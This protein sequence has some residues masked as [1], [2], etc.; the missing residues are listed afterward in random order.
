MIVILTGLASSG[1]LG[2]GIIL[3]PIMLIFFR[4]T[5]NK[6]IM[7]VYAM[8]FG[9][10]IG[11]FLNAGLKRHPK[12]RKPFLNY[13]LSLICMPPM[14]MGTAFGV[15]INRM[16]ASAFI[17]V[18][19]VTLITYSFTKIYGRARTEYK[20][21]TEARKDLAKTTAAE[22][23]IGPVNNESEEWM[24]FDELKGILKEENQLVP[25]KKLLKTLGLIVFMIIMALLRGT[26]NFSSLAGVEYC[27]EEYWLLF[28]LAP[29][30]CLV[31][32]A[33]N[34]RTLKKTLRVKNEAGYIP[35][36]GEFELN[37]KHV[38]KLSI[39]SAFAGVLAG[40][41]GIG[42]G[43]IMGPTLLSI[44]V[45]PQSLGATAGFFIIQTSFMSFFS[46]L[47]YGEI[48]LVE[49]GF[50]LGITFIGSYVVSYILS[51]LVRKYNRPSLILF[52]LIFVLGTA[53]VV[54]PTFEILNHIDNLGE[55]MQFSSAC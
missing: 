20:K 5:E 34:I 39:L 54:T 4:Y 13:D 1:G 36:E 22:S 50:F 38:G 21:E 16:I 19:L 31:A 3:T 17:V 55:L 14:L 48:P 27:G 23:L 53:W 41:F 46:A 24:A 32:S 33:L 44:G 9:G 40:M 37:D 2:G 51:G 15:I 7:I 6:A 42:G 47:L 12:T 35:K 18:G 10:A 8:I 43:M 25:W 28:T 11:N 29:L 26:K 49:Y 45:D 30:G 52:T